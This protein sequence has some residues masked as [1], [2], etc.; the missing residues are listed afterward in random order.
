[1]VGVRCVKGY[2]ICA[3]FLSIYSLNYLIGRVCRWKLFSKVGGGGSFA[4]FI[5][6]LAHPPTLSSIS[7][8]AQVFLVLNVVNSTVRELELLPKPC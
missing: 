2:S 1:M 5:I 7:S 3:E 6:I 8:C 4:M